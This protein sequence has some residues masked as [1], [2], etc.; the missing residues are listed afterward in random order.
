M[1]SR[2]WRQLVELDHDKKLLSRD[3]TAVDLRLPDRVT[4]RLSDEAAQA[5][6]EAL[7]RRKDGEGK[8]KGE[9]R[10]TSL[11]YGVTPKM[12]PISP[13]RS[14][15][16]AALDVGT[17]KIACLIAR[18]R[19]LAQQ[20][21]LRAPHPCGRDPRHRPHALARHQGAAPS[22]TWT[23]PSRR[24]ALPSTAPSAWPASQSIPS[25]CRSSAGR[26]ASEFSAPRRPVAARR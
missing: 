12:K 7:A 17:S 20:D 22:S 2:R 15:V 5:R 23:Q 10:M 4:V 6:E 13:R 9:R 8:R 3:I 1:S 19:P 25:S 18:L 14:A 24:S 26:L 16:V 11:H 21:V